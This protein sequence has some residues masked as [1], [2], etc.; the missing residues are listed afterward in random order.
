MS[1]AIRSSTINFL[2]STTSRRCLF[3]LFVLKKDKNFMLHMSKLS[4]HEKK[5]S[6]RRRNRC[7]AK[8]FTLEEAEERRMGNKVNY[9]NSSSH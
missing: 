8:I 2:L 1:K 9:H 6:L 3:F 5:K 7:C 4:A